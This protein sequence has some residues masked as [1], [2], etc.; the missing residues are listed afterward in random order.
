MPPEPPLP[1]L[2]P[3]YLAPAPTVLPPYL[4]GTVPTGTG[5]AQAL[6]QPAGPQTLPAQPITPAAT[7]TPMS[8]Y[9]SAADLAPLFDGT[10]GWVDTA[11]NLT[12]YIQP[13]GHNALNPVMVPYGTDG[14]FVPLINFYGTSPYGAF[15]NESGV[16]YQAIDAT[17]AADAN[18]AINATYASSLVTGQINQE[19]SFQP[20]GQ[21]SQEAWHTEVGISAMGT[22]Q[23]ANF[24]DGGLNWFG[25]LFDGTGGNVANATNLTG[26]IQPDGFNAASSVA[27]PHKDYQGYTIFAPLFGTNPWSGY[28]EIGFGVFFDE[29]GYAN[30]ARKAYEAMHASGNAI[31]GFFS[32]QHQ[33]QPAIADATDTADVITRVNEILAALRHWTL[34][35]T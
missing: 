20:G 24:T 27:A 18:Y 28:G 19:F 25:S 23:A 1:I 13:D 10:G 9:I 5:E 21:Y 2:T 32:G 6:P 35:N 12:G 11:V 16:A 7:G 14:D 3:A 31:S 34:I 29:N 30:Y 8:P 4:G 22:I 15:F 33:Q 26:T 17:H